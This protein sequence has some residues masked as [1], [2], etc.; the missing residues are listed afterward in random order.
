ML[1][2]RTIDSKWGRVD[3]DFAG[4]IVFQSA[5]FYGK[6]LQ[7]CIKP[8][9]SQGNALGSLRPVLLTPLLPHAPRSAR[10]TPTHGA[11]DSHTAPAE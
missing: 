7:R 5:Q 10:L 8:T 6:I 1:L 2:I 4:C 11:V 3:I 9:L